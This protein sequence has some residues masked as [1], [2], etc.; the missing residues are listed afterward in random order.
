MRPLIGICANYSYDE[1]IGTEGA[2]GARGQE[3]QVL[4]DDYIKAVERAGG[5]PVILPITERPETLERILDLLDGVILSGGTDLDPRFYGEAPH[6]GLGMVDARRDAHEIVLAKKVLYGTEL[7]ILAICRGC[8][9]LAVVS[10]GSLYQ[11]LR[12]ERP[13]SFNHSLPNGQ[14]DHLSHSVTVSAQSKLHHLFAD[15]EVMVNSFHHQAIKQ[16][17][18]GFQITMQAPDGVIEGIEQSGERFVVGVQWHPEMIIDQGEVY[19]QL[20]RLFV[21][22]ASLRKNQVQLKI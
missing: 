16:A 13:N 22:Q 14:K 9:L 19:Q 4:A 7:P 17:G 5:T 3:W 11:D 1:R 21:E 12:T 6:F 18:D 2:M 8:Q 15:G 10:G 20:F